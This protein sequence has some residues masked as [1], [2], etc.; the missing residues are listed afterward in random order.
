VL[1]LEL[2][3]ETSQT[4]EQVC[5]YPVVSDLNMLRSALVNR[6]IPGAALITGELIG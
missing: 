3:S 1:D 4:T 6:D 5:A 2:P